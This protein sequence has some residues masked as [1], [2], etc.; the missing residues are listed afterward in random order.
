MT[1][2]IKKP[3]KLIAIYARVST[4][5]Q[6]E[7]QTIKT[8]ISAIKDFAKQ[9]GYTIVQ[10]Y[11][12]DGWSGDFLARP[13]L[14]QLRQDAK[15]KIW[16]AVLMYDPDRL[17]RRAAWQ[18]VVIE[19]LK[20][21]GI[22]TI[23]TTIPQPKNDEDVI[24]YKMRG[25]FSEYER[26]KIKER[27]R[28]GKISRINNGHVLTTE[29]PYGYTYILNKGKKGKEG[30]VPGHYKINKYEAK[31][32]KQIFHMVADE[33]LTLRGVVRRLHELKIRPRK[34]KRGGWATSTLPTRLRN[35]AYIGKA[36]WRASY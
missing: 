23:F 10:E 2:E 1:N 26:M 4:S 12:D 6:E 5:H 18:E 15:K 27:F 29:A 28:L 22:P 20:E 31:I 19:E 33:R 36:R 21:S 32:L 7:Q 13:E 9:N 3:I 16:D 25:V 8:Q 17:A 11:T 34:S 14:D 30:Y 24:M 35:T